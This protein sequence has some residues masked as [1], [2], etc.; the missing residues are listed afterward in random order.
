MLWSVSPFHLEVSSCCFFS[1][2]THGFASL[3]RH[4]KQEAIKTRHLFLNT[5]CPQLFA[6]IILK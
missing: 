5:D 4:F 6:S 2:V 3:Q 1:R